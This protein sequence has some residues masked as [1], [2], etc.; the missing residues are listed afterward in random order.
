MP[1]NPNGKTGPRRS[2]L[3]ANGFFPIPPFGLPSGKCLEAYRRSGFNTHKMA[4]SFS[5]MTDVTAYAQRISDRAKEICRRTNRPEERIVLVGWSLGGIAAFYALKR[6]GLNRFAN[7]FVSFGAPFGGS[8]LAY[9][10]LPTVIYSLVGSQIR[11]NGPFLT[12]LISGGLPNGV[13]C[14]SIGGRNDAIC[15]ADSAQLP[16]AENITAD[17]SHS[18][19]L[20][21]RR[22]H[23]LIAENLP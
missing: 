18:S 5:G 11:P 8:D 17:F 13:R 15:P 23:A 10:G 16:G 3:I 9:T 4:W 12:D 14:L 20:F 2:V 19:F 6:L 7:R 22:L 1:E 21:N